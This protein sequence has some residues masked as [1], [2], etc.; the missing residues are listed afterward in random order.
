ML[1]SNSKPAAALDQWEVRRCFTE[2]MNA[3]GWLNAGL[4]CGGDASWGVKGQARGVG[5]QVKLLLWKN[6]TIRKRQKVIFTLS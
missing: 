4:W 2:H 3:V 5:Y 6:W 1:T